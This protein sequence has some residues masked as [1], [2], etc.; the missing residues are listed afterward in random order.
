M[1]SN[2]PQGYRISDSSLWLE[3]YGDYLFRYALYRLNDRDLAED[4][5]QETFLAA[6]AAREKYS[7]Q[8][9][10]KTWLTAI[11]KNKIVD[12]YRKQGR[13][14]SLEEKMTATAETDS[15]FNTAGSNKGQWRIDRRPAEWMVDMSDA[16]EVKEFWLFLND[17]LAKLPQ[18]TA[19]LYVLR[20]IE[21]V[22]PG[23]ICNDLSINP[24]NLRVMIHR[25]RSQWR[26]CLET[27]WLNK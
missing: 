1:K 21:D 26:R 3:K 15:D 27:N 18:T 4:V 8:S 5:V 19:L 16:T 10:E 2:Q 11:L 14:S 22:D 13:D 17:C 23:D 12:Q 24:T 25:A 20:E 7:G 6:L 9:S